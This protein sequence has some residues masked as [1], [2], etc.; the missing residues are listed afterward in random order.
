[1]MAKQQSGGGSA[2]GGT[3]KLSSMY[4]RRE[5]DLFPPQMELS[6]IDGDDR[7]TLRYE[8]VEW[9]VEG[10]RRGLRYG[11]NPGQSAALYRLVYGNLS[12]GDVECVKPGEYASAGL[13][14]LKSGK[15]P[16]KINVTDADA[17]LEIL[18]YLTDSPACVVVKHNNP[19]GVARSDSIH[20]AYEAA[21]GADPVAA[22]GG[23]VAV[24]RPIDPGTAEAIAERYAEVVVAPGFEE[25]VLDILGRRKNLRV[26][27]IRNMDRL[28]TFRD[29][30]YVDFTSLMDGS[31]ITQLSYHAEIESVD[32]FMDATAE[33]DGTR[34]EMERRPTDQEARDLLFAWHV[35]TAVT[36][37]SVVY[38]KNGVTV[39][40]GT[41]EQDRVGCARFARDKAYRNASERIAIREYGKSFR[42]LEEPVRRDIAERVA[43]DNADLRG[44]AMA[45]DAFFPFRDGADVGLSEGVTAI[46]QPGGSLRDHELISACNE[47]GASMVFTGQR[48]F[49]H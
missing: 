25:G 31:L 42:F 6:F 37:N 5:K 34:Y 45:S 48:A 38:V 39:G 49:R 21:Y 20:A 2:G 26:F 23:V 41:G 36:S 44:A 40:I 22:F 18:K 14:L 17:A 11:E 8:K 43:S 24:N 32:D 1:M 27:R 47:Y 28:A 30:R 19:S 15:H 13:E 4:R 33:R 35:C 9:E 46:V 29:V 12:L 7:R 3:G 16:G 10:E